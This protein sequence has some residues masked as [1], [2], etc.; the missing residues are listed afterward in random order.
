MLGIID[1]HSVRLFRILLLE[2]LRIIVGAPDRILVRVH[3][4]GRL[5]CHRYLPEPLVCGSAERRLGLLAHHFGRLASPA[6]STVENVSELFKLLSVID[7][8]VFIG[9]V[10]NHPLSATVEVDVQPFV[11]NRRQEP[12]GLRQLQLALLDVIDSRDSVSP[13]LVWD[14]VSTADVLHYLLF[15]VRRKSRRILAVE[16]ILSVEGPSRDILAP[17]RPGW[18][19]TFLQRAA[20]HLR[21]L[22]LDVPGEVLAVD[23]SALVAHVV[24]GTVCGGSGPGK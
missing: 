13:P 8:V 22:L 10:R 18:H 2:N 4:F 11:L 24:L 12:M 1:C 3:A 5:L 9:D 23:V 17:E 15:H 14:K 6:S 16:D 7:F 19:L 21:M 20:L